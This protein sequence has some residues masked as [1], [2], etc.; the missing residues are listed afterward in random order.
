MGSP[1]PPKPSN[2]QF[3]ALPPYTI[4]AASDIPS[5][6]YIKFFG[7]KTVF[8]QIPAWCRKVGH[9]IRVIKEEYPNKYSK[10]DPDDITI[11]TKE[12]GDAL[13]FDDP[14]E[15]VL[16]TKDGKVVN[17]KP[18]P[19]A[20]ASVKPLRQSYVIKKKKEVPTLWRVAK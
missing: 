6:L 3:N 15:N 8:V 5:E 1:S 14:L 12:D 10:Y 20:G 13:E 9:L 16:P 11:C 7:G 2:S 18:H 17:D 4:M 19:L